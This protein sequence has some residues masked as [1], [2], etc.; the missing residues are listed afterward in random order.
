MITDREDVLRNA[1]EFMADD[2]TDLLRWLILRK[3]HCLRCQLQRDDLPS[4]IFQRLKELH[5]IVCFLP[6]DR[7]LRSQSGLGDLFSRGR[8]RVSRQIDLLHGASVCRSE[9]RPDIPERAD[10]MGEETDLS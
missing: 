6:R 7:L 8:S 5:M 9:E 1:G 2:Q 4:I 3:I 10:I